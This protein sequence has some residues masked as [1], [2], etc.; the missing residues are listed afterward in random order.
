MRKVSSPV[1]S[2]HRLLSSR[3]HPLMEN[4]VTQNNNIRIPRC[5][6]LLYV[7]YLAVDLRHATSKLSLSKS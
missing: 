2:K 6:V 7:C 3:N 1:T 4:V 5:G